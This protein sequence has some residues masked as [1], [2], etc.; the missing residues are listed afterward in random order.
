MKKLHIAPI[1]AEG[2]ALVAAGFAYLTEF[3]HPNGELIER[4]YVRNIIPIEGLN[5]LAGVSI[6]GAAQI[7]DWFLALHAANYTPVPGL[8]A[9]TYAADATEFL[10]YSEAARVRAV[11]GT[12]AGGACDNSLSKAS[13]TWNATGTAYG[14]ALLSASPMGAATGICLSAVKFPSPK[15]GDAGAVLN[16][17][18][19]I[20]FT[21]L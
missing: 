17:T 21:S 13:F 10:G 4:E 19:G 14:G 6:K 16:V 2:N 7:S 15:A 1:T 9:S 5:Y 20:A 12:V 11:F 18:T 3:Y 8:Q